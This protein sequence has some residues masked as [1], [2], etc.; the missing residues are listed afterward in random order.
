MSL[1][2]FTDVDG[3]LNVLCIWNS[4]TIYGSELGDHNLS[5]PYPSD[6]TDK[7]YKTA[8]ILKIGA[9]EAHVTTAEKVRMWKVELL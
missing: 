3:D 5:V 2:Y 1:C 9:V 6:P 8:S 4:L 7:K